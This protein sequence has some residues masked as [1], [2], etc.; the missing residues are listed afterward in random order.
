MIVTAKMLKHID[1]IETLDVKIFVIQTIYFILTI[2]LISH[3][4]KIIIY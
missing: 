3:K 4:L 2:L 1:Q